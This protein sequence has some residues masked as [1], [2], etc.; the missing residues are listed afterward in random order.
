MKEGWVLFL[1]QQEGT[2]LFSALVWPLIYNVWSLTIILSLWISVL[3]FE[4]SSVLIYHTE[5]MKQREAECL[6]CEQ[7]Q[8]WVNT[9]RPRAR[10]WVFQHHLIQCLMHN[11]NKY[12]LNECTLHQDILA[13]E[14]YGSFGKGKCVKSATR[15]SVYFPHV[16]E[17]LTL[18][19]T[20]GRKKN[21]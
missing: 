20:T 11:L 1:G 13:T 4:I 7:V 15:G 19:K 3:C 9:G 8:W 12:L 18:A 16:I 5:K 10:L 2:K 14:I 21:L 6:C 17:T